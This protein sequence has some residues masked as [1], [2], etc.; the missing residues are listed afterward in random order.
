M[1]ITMAGTME[2]MLP[3]AILVADTGDII[4]PLNTVQETPCSQRC[5]PATTERPALLVLESA[6]L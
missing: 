1:G 5:F 3:A 6:L 2:V 4:D